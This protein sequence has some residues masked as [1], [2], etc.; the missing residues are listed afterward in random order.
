MAS[1][2]HGTEDGVATTNESAQ[3]DAKNTVQSPAERET[4]VSK[5]MPADHTD[6]VPAGQGYSNE[7]RAYHARYDYVFPTSIKPDPFSKN[8]HDVAILPPRQ[9]PLH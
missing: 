1:K 9:R 7:A 6:A 2:K 3:G 8:Y 5:L 4:N